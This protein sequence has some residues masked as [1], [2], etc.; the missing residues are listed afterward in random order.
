MPS[1]RQQL[2]DEVGGNLFSAPWGEDFCRIWNQTA[3]HWHVFKAVGYVRFTSVSEQYEN[4]LSLFWGA[5]GSV[6]L[7]SLLPTSRNPHFCSSES[8]WNRFIFGS[9]SPVDAVLSGLI[10]Y[11]GPI[12]FALMHGPKFSNVREVAAQV[13][14]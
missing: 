7:A 9:M 10:V 3:T 4:S 13:R 6:K 14:M 8:Q 5:D 11:R 12:V 2:A 1:D